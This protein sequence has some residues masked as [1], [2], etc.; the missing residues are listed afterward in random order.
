MR[1]G[2]LLAC[3]F[4]WVG[5]TEK[6]TTKN[7]PVVTK[8]QP[9]I[10]YIL[11]DDLGYGD[12]AAFNTQG[13]IKTPHIDQLASEG[14]KFTD[15]HSP[16][17]VCSPTRYGIITG[18]YSWRSPM[19]S[20]VLTGKSKALISK[21]RTTVASLLQKGG[22]HTAFIGKWHLGWNWAQKDSTN[23]G[24]EGWNAE[25]FDNLDFE[26]NVTHSPNDLGFDYAYGHAGSLDMAPYVY[27]EN[28]KIT[29]KV[30]HI[31]ENKEKYS[32][33]RKGYTAA[34]FVHEEVT[35]HFFKKAMSY[36]NERAQAKKPFFMYLALPSPHTPIL[37][38]KEWQG[39]SKLNPYADFVMMVDD[40]VGQLVK[41]VDAAGLTENTL[42]VFTSDNGCSPEADFTVLGEKGHNPSGMYRGHKADIYEA[43][44]RVP[45]IMKW[46][47][48]IAPNSVSH[49]TI[50][51]TDF[52]ATCADIIGVP[53][54]SNEGVDSFSLLP[55]FNKNSATTYQR[56]ATVHHSINGS[57]AIRKG[58]YKL[59]FCP[60]SGGWSYPKPGK[61]DMTGLPKFQLY[62]LKADPAE[63]NNIYDAHPEIVTELTAL[64][65]SYIENGRSTP[66]SKQ[67]NAPLHL[68]GSE[69]QQIN[70]I[71]SQ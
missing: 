62:N 2:M 61:D 25:D 8:Q 67:K 34:D 7:A 69:W 5:C 11:T 40:Y 70:P 22:Y 17:A 39:K 45:Y 15:A 43:G 47:G 30:D 31:T 56:E 9:N 57:F 55:L 12:I 38:T 28:G 65:A 36:V 37:P 71:V 49:Q 53:L 4:I 50:C 18:R 6:K 21:N 29:A 66:G 32:W 27:V 42:I 14:M 51:Q 63:K 52:M 3:S 54:A 64:M 1:I 23:F 68:D 41:A 13:K 46:P 35:P 20:G 26:K 58:D 16:S 10:I 19:K 33:W 24:G 44:H 60:G 59:I 48:H